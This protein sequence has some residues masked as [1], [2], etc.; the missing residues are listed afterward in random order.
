MWY[1]ANWL[2]VSI[3]Y[4]NF[5]CYLVHPWEYHGIAQ[6]E[7]LFKKNGAKEHERKTFM[8]GKMEAGDVG[9]WQKNRALKITFFTKSLQSWDLQF[10]PIYGKT[11]LFFPNSTGT[12]P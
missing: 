10:F 8:K 6:T 9:I 11:S 7:K 5:K 2:Q 4:L 3:I 1:Q 12:S